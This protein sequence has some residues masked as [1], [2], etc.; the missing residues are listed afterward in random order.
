LAALGVALTAVCSTG[1]RADTPAPGLEWVRLIGAETCVSASQLAQRVEARVGRTLF[2]SASTAALFIDGYV[3]APVPGRWHVDLAVEDAEGR[4]LGR[5]AFDF[6]GAD[7][8]VIDEALTLVIAVTLYPNSGLTG[9]GIPLDE[10][11]ASHLD[12]L[13]GAEPTDPD[14]ATLPT[15]TPAPQPTTA[16][17]VA[18]EPAP[19]SA[20][21]EPARADSAGIGVDLV[22]ASGLGQLPGVA[23]G[24]GVRIV[25]AIAPLW[26]IELDFTAFAPT[27]QEAGV[28]SAGSARFDALYGSLA[29]CPWQASGLSSL[30]LCAGAEIG[31]ISIDPRHFEGQNAASSDAIANLIGGAVLRA[32]ISQSLRLRLALTGLLPVWQ[33]SYT[34]QATDGTSLRLFRMSQIA[35]RA[36]IGMGLAF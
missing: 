2:A 14:P 22:G 19:A 12:A 15:N 26:P 33:R 16:A 1:A 28:H 34:F 21:P 6:E 20:E 35:G 5:R 31:R 24:A 29:T 23:F 7:C 36:E 8:S 9:S 13:F 17:T 18:S 4:V 10:G 32:R 30:S 25:F 11:T 3:S 27:T